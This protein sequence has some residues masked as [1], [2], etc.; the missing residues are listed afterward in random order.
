A[1]EAEEAQLPLDAERVSRLHFRGGDARAR[2]SSEALPR[3]EHEI[4][5]ARLAGRLHGG[6]DP[7]TRLPDLG[8]RRPRE[9]LGEFVRAVAGEE[10][11]RVRLDEARSDEL[12]LR[13]D[14]DAV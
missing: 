11:V 2:Q 1:D 5:V 6:D 3:G 14:L 9:A 4:L 12:S 8:I 10:Q 7:A 13:V